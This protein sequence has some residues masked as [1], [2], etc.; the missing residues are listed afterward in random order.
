MCPAPVSRSAN[1]QATYLMAFV[2]LLGQRRTTAADQSHN[3]SAYSWH[4]P[5]NEN[6]GHCLS[7]EDIDRSTAATGGGKQR[8]RI[9]AE[10]EGA[11]SALRDLGSSRASVTHVPE[12]DVCCA[13]RFIVT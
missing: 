8:L 2:E 6:A 9:R 4:D 1:P 3:G 13:H 11:T 12:T 5:I 10:P 7:D